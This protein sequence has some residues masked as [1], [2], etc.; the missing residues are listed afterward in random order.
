MNLSRK[1]IRRLLNKNF[2]NYIGFHLKE[3]VKE[4]MRPPYDR[5]DYEDEALNLIEIIKEYTMVSLP[6]LITLYQQIRYLEVNNIDGALVECGVW[7]GGAVGLMALSQLKFGGD[8]RRIIH[9][10]DS[11]K[12]LPKAHPKD[13]RKAQAWFG[14]QVGGII[15]ESNVLKAN[16]S[17]CKKLLIDK[18]GY[19]TDYISFHKGWFQETIPLARKSGALKKIALLRLDGDLYEST[20]TCLEYLWDLVVPQ[21]III[22]DDYAYFEGCKKAVDE[23][24]SK[25]GFYPILNHIEDGGGRYIIKT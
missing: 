20:K 12:G 17:V 1:R 7:K 11:F 21:G 25:L 9:L 6:R 18:I 2:F 14:T 19:P 5:Y 15:E 8:T 10:F 4:H 3:K 22:I 24:F 16:I 23:F 13:D